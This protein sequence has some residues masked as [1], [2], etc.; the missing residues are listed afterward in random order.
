MQDGIVISV[1]L[2]QRIITVFGVAT[3]NALIEW[4]D[5]NM[6]TVQGICFIALVFVAAVQLSRRSAKPRLIRFVCLLYC[7]HQ[8]RRL[9]NGGSNTL[10]NLFPNLLLAIS[11]AVMLMVVSNNNSDDSAKDLRPMLEG[12]TYMYGD[13][14]DFLFADEGSV[15][16]TTLAAFC[17]GILIETAAP[18][19]DPTI[20]FV[21]RLAGIISANLLYQGVTSFINASAHME[22]IETIATA[23]ILRLVLPSMEGYLMFMTAGQ[24]AALAPGIA[25]I[26]FCIVMWLDCLPSSS[27]AW[28]REICIT[29]VL[30]EAIR[31]L[32]SISTGGSMVILIMAHYADYIIAHPPGGAGERASKK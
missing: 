31:Y 10:T 3:V 7:N 19:S 18:P 20:N 26:M 12:L 15:I 14:L 29:Y 32:S 5:R 17:A 22:I 11:V 27:H 28:V 13:T 23:S 16:P 2:V 8:L 21:R 9:F 25:P 6:D 30:L 1:R 4:S 24:L